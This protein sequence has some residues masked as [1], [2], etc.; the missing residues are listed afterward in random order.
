MNAADLL[1]DSVLRHQLLRYTLANSHRVASS[2]R[3]SHV[4]RE[5]GEGIEFH[6]F[7]PYLP[8]DDLRRVDWR[9][10]GRT[11]RHFVREAEQE[12]RLTVCLF[13]DTTASMGMRDDAAPSRL[14]VARRVAAA[15]AWLSAQ[16][17]HDF[18]LVTLTDGRP[19]YLPPSAGS[20]QL[21]RVLTSLASLT[22]SGRWPRHANVRHALRAL[23]SH[24]KVYCFSDFFERGDEQTRAMRELLGMAHGLSSVQILTD[25]ELSFRYRGQ[26]EVVDAEHGDVQL[27][28]ARSYRPQYL[29]RLGAL[30]DAVRRE[31]LALGARVVRVTTST[32]MSEVLRATLD[33]AL[34]PAA[35]LL[36]AAGDSA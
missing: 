7:R 15:I 20:G 6:Q 21:Q 13:I 3:A 2:L 11:D 30:L 28:D 4:S 8:G 14:H 27:V 34:T 12:S 33:P 10:Y 36:A 25:A 5:R 1:P 16:R 23:P 35:R 26:V 24:S 19:V 29:A 18:G 17:H 31:Q 32:P 22:P 9:L